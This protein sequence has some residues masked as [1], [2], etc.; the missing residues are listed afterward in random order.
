MKL[1]EILAA[2]ERFAPLSIQE[3]WDNAGLVCGDPD[4]DVTGAVVGFDC[5]KEL[6]CEAVSR[7]ANLVVTHH[8]LIFKGVKRI[9]PGEPVS[10]ALV[11]AIK[12][13]VAVYAAHTNADKVM[14]GVSGAMG[15]S[16]GIFRNR[17]P[18]KNSCRR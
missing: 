6:I 16:S 3:S 2:I 12:N 13:D 17:C 14:E 1:Y 15:E 10:A 11:A 4:M 9:L 18:W 5:T 8:P 7:G